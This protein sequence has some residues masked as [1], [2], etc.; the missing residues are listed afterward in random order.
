MERE[1]IFKSDLQWSAATTLWVDFFT[2]WSCVSAKSAF[3]CG[4][5]AVPTKVDYFITR[6]PRRGMHSICAL[7]VGFR[8]FRYRGRD[9]NGTRIR[10]RNARRWRRCFKVAARWAKA[11][12][13]VPGWVG[14]LWSGAWS[15]WLA[16]WYQC[17]DILVP[18]VRMWSEYHRQEYSSI[19]TQTKRCG[20]M[21]WSPT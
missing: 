6:R 7:R 5:A 1:V 16:S 3:L 9:E 18:T 20:D 13:R 10:N 17:L 14:C 15:D 8:H 11:G 12:G 21:F 2:K 19:E 4:W